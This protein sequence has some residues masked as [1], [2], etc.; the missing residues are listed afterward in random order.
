MPCRAQPFFAQREHRLQPR[1]GSVEKGLAAHQDTPPE[2]RALLTG[3]D[4]PI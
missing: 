2:S 1:Y 3:E 4:G